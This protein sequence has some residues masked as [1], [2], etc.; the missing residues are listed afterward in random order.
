M[1]DVT[2]EYCVPCGLLEQAVETQTALLER[3]GRDLDGV[4]L[5]P[6]HGG[7]FKVH[8]GGET[9][10]DEDVHGADFDPEL[11]GDAVADRVVSADA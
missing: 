4:T 3:F 9:V 10:W 5:E 1:T 7:V 8:A 6:G 2:I 11:I